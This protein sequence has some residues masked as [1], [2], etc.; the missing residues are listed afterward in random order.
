[1]QIRL[2]ARGHLQ[3]VAAYESGTTM[4]KFLSQPSSAGIFWG[5]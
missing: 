5:G 3:E 4:A 2:G 1:M